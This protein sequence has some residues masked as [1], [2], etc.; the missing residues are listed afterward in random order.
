MEKFVVL[1]TGGKQYLVKKGDLLNIEKIDGQPG[2][3]IMLDNVLLFFDLSKK[4]EIGKPLLKMVVKAEILEQQKAP[5]IVV[6]KYKSKNRYKRKQGH[7][8]LQTK[9][10]ILSFTSAQVKKPAKS[11]V[12][13]KPA[14]STVKKTK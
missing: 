1:K 8:Q 12:K 7:R 2:D 5:K 9:I 13:K 11:T 3:K 10:K 6:I 4:I 14:K